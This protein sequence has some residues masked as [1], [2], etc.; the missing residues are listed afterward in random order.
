MDYMWS[1]S[2]S[3]L[4][5]R[6]VPQNIWLLFSINIADEIVDGKLFV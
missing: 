1:F 3:E 5:T 4:L 6:P 2:L